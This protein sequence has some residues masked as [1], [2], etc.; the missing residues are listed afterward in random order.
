MRFLAFCALCLTGAA[1]ATAE[2][3][4]VLLLHAVPASSSFCES[5]NDRTLGCSQVE[6][7]AAGDRDLLVWVLISDVGGSL[8]GVEFGIRYDVTVNVAGWVPC[9]GGMENPD[10]SW[11]VSGSGI[12]CVWPAGC[13]ETGSSDMAKVGFLFVRAGSSGRIE[14]I[15]HAAIGKVVWSTCYPGPEYDGCAYNGFV[16]IGGG[17]GFLPSQCECTGPPGIEATWGAI[18]A[19][20][21]D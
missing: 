11:P 14:V 17:S 4:A 2:P 19:S 5:I 6:V 10:P 7:A 21:R 12:A 20:Y 18:K 3:E 1:A 8:G 15:E 13:Y 9:T 16:Q